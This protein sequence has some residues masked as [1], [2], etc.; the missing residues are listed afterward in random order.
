VY[1]T[2]HDRIYLR[3]ESVSWATR[4]S[5]I[6]SFPALTVKPC[7]E[8]SYC[9]LV[10]DRQ[11]LLGLI[12]AKYIKKPVVIEAVQWFEMGDH[13]EVIEIPEKYKDFNPV[14]EGATG[15]IET[16]EGGH[17][18]TTGDWII[19]DVEGE[20]YACKP[21]IFDKTYDFFAD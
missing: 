16:L 6:L 10:I 20:Y 1:E 17:F 13:P 12:M 2:H 4:P 3:E 15:Y 9:Y 8:F 19:R 7:I 14:I 5:Q 18:V 21:D 11:N